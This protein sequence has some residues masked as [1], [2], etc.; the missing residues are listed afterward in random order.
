[1]ARSR[2]RLSTTDRGYGS[3]HQKRVAAA[4]AEW[5]PGQPCARC[6]QAIT[7]LTMTDT[8]GRTVSAVDLGHVDGTGKRVY[9][10]LEHRRCS[11]SA[12]AS[13]GNQQRGQAQQRSQ[14]QAWTTSRTW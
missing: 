12:G 11:R 7:T 10:G 8:R 5:W 1:M 3:D 4:K 13:L 9:Q 14:A 2:P 6:G